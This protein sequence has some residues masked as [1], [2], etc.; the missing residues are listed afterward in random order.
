MNL[1]IVFTFVVLQIGVLFQNAVGQKSIAFFQNQLSEI[2]A[3]SDVNERRYRQSIF[4]DEFNNWL[5]QNEAEEA[6]GTSS[7]HSVTTDD[8]VYALYYYTQ[9]DLKGIDY[10][11]FVK[12]N[13]ETGDVQVHHF[14]ETINLDNKAAGEVREPVIRLTSQQMSGLKMYEVSFS[15]SDNPLVWRRYSDLKLKCMF[16]EI[17]KTKEDEKKLAINRLVL[18]RLKIIWQSPVMYEDDFTG[19]ARMKTLFSKDKDIKISTYGISF[20]DFTNL[21]YGAV[22]VKDNKGGI[23]VNLLTDKSDGIR[24]PTRASLTAN[25]WYGATYLDIIE[26]H[27]QKKKY[28]TL[29]GYKGQDE[30]VKKRVV[31]VMMISGGKPRFGTQLFKQGRY[32]YSRL[33]FQYSLGANMLLRYDEKEKMIVMDNLVPSDPNYKGVFRFYGPDF[34]YN[35]YKFEKGKWVLY[36]NIDLR[37]PK[38]N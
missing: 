27:Y 23:N 2:L 19:I 13:N 14:K 4:N 1:R 18:R 5:R 33:I 16:E 31:D 10:Q 38:S 26:T 11:F 22:I 36:N 17:G 20:S 35:G 15:D 3:N 21:F 8:D 9:H 12:Y 32:T 28:Y 29:I 24:S 25:K 34:S 37:N 30:F 7:L 6:Q